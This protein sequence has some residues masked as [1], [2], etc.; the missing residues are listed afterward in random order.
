MKRIDMENWEPDETIP[1]LRDY[2]I[3]PYIT[4][5]HLFHAPEG[6]RKPLGFHKQYQIQYVSHGL[7]HYVVEDREYLTRKGDLI[8]HRPHEK[9]HVFTEPG[10]PYS[11]ISIVFHFGSAPFPV[12]DLLGERH[13]FAGLA[14]H[15]IDELLQEIV[16]HYHQPGVLRQMEC[17]QQLMRTLAELAKLSRQSE[18]T[19]VQLKHKTILLHVKNYIHARFAEDVRLDELEEVSGLSRNYLCHLF[20]QEFGM[21]PL[22]YL[23]WLRVQRAKDLAIQTKLSVSQI[24]AEVGYSDV[25]TFGKMFKK[26]TGISLSQYCASLYMTTGGE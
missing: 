15:P 20:R 26:K 10:E 23:T 25:H 4:L 8:L 24:A 2:F 21:L 16:S 9:H 12:K 22:Q 13:Y 17:Q 7:A 14:D 5:A 11:C 1:M 3:P 18:M 19:P 6:W